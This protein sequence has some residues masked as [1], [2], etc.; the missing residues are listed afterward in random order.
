ME[1]LSRGNTA[2]V[3]KV[4]D[5]IVVL[6]VKRK[7]KYIDTDAVT[8]E[9]NEDKDKD[10]IKETKFGDGNETSMPKRKIE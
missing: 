2:E 3:K 1:I 7:I 4:K 9:M 10:V 6:E 5:G 8:N